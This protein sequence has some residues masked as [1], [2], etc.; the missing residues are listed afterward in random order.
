MAGPGDAT[1]ALVWI[2]KALDAGRLTLSWHAEHERM[3][4]RNI[5]WPDIQSCIRNAARCQPYK[6]GKPERGGTCWRVYGPDLDEDREIAIGFEAYQDKKRD[7][8]VVV[9]VIDPS[10]DEDEKD[11]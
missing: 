7:S 11:E 8:G 4:E 5:D 1:H 9:T 6:N 10:K 2:R 3:I